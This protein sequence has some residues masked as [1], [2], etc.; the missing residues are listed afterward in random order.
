MT[1]VTNI[2]KDAL[3]ALYALIQTTANG[4]SRMRPTPNKGKP[5]R[6]LCSA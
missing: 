4:R 5:I 1:S 3:H 6:P 2:G